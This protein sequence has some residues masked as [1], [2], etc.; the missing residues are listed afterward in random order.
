MPYE[1]VTEPIS[2]PYAFGQEGEAATLSVAAILLALRLRIRGD[3]RRLTAQAVDVVGRAGESAVVALPDEDIA[4][5]G[6]PMIS[7]TG[8]RV[9][10]AQAIAPLVEFGF[11]SG[12][13][14]LPRD[15]IES[16]AQMFQ[17]HPTHQSVAALFEACLRHPE[18][19]VRVAAA[20]A[21]LDVTTQPEGPLAILRQALTTDDDQTREV[22]AVC[23]ARYSPEDPA[24]QSILREG[25]FP[26]EGSPANS[27]I[28]VHGTRLLRL[29]T[30]WQ[31]GSAFHQ[32]FVDHVRS[33]VYTAPDPF[34]WDAG[35]SDASRAVGAVDLLGWARDKGLTTLDIVAHSHGG[36]LAMLATQGGLDL[37]ELVLLSCPVRIPQYLPQFKRVRKIVSVRVHMDIMVLADRA[38]QIFNLPQIEEHVLPIWFKHS[39]THEPDVWKEFNIGQWL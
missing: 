26:E 11:D 39:A 29:S 33:D 17:D 7:A 28:F 34:F 13:S 16:V 2:S 3:D 31:H 9:D 35:Y 20:A 14:E 12:Q 32:Y 22:A 27:W 15:V 25:Q 19:L 6:I 4:R 21:Y 1:P 30:W 10:S 8:E 5:L 38:G 37:E 23:L 18:E 24:L 36:N